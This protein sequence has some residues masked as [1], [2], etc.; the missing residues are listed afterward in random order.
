M[1]LMEGKIAVI[2]GVANKR[3]IAWGITSALVRE[4]AR[5]ALNY[6][7][8]RMEPGVRKL[9]KDL[10]DNTFVAQCDVTKKDEVERSAGKHRPRSLRIKTSPGRPRD[11]PVPI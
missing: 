3:S 11:S 1:G 6:Q 7:N 4:G 2:F 8:E 9:A 5:V 10:P